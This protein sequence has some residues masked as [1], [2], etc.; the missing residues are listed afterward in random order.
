MRYPCGFVK[1]LKKTTKKTRV[2]MS[3]LKFEAGFFPIQG[4]TAT[5]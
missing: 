4:S 3:R 1:E 5:V 2:T